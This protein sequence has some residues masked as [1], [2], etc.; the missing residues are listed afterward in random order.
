MKAKVCLSFDEVFHG[1]PGSIHLANDNTLVFRCPRAAECKR[2]FGDGE[3]EC[4]GIC[5][6]PVNRKD[7]AGRGWD[8]TGWPD[9]VTL[10][11]SVFNCQG[12]KCQWH[13]WLRNGEWVNA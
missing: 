4:R 3:T 12:Q 7:A 9:S 6:I 5:Q 2:T 13:G 10:S 11:P 1:E 8:M